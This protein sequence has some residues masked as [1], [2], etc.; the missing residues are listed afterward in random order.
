MTA[1]FNFNRNFMICSTLALA[2]IFSATAFATEGERNVTLQEDVSSA[3]LLR[4]AIPAGEVLVTGTTGNNL[5]A[6]VTATCKKERKACAEF[7]AKLAW[8]KKTGNTTELQL[9]PADMSNYNDITIKV[10]IGVPKDKKL[11][12]SLAAGELTLED[13]SGCVSADVS[14]GQLNLKL[15]ESQL[16]S[17]EL[18]ANVGDAKLITAKGETIAGDR[19]LLVGATLDWAK[20]AGT[21]HAKAGV[22]AGEVKLVIN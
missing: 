21:C 3:E 9:K 2:N 6:V 18:R 13:T 4:L 20:G 16:A 14:A 19:S 8:D 12:V 7:L 1:M 10:K 22:T 5:T 17:A 11:E 15:K